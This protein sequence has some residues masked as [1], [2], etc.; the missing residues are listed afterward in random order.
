MRCVRIVTHE[1]HTSFNGADAIEKRLFAYS[2][3]PQSTHDFLWSVC[4]ISSLRTW[5]CTL[6][7]RYRAERL[8][9]CR[10]TLQCVLSW[11]IRI[12]NLVMFVDCGITASALQNDLHNKFVDTLRTIHANNL[13]FELNVWVKDGTIADA[14]LHDSP[15][16]NEQGI[17]GAAEFY[18][19]RLGEPWINPV[20]PRAAPVSASG[21]EYTHLFC[22]FYEYTT[23]RYGERNN[24]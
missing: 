1:R 6:P 23:G 16:F 19:T 2:L 14:T 20:L 22:Y 18:R 8:P 15:P 21:V 24:C 13:F 4:S 12:I 10:D 11:H 7:L 5:R 17:A 9:R 3:P